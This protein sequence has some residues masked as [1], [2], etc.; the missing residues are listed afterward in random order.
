[1]AHRRFF[2]PR[3]GKDYQEG[4]MG[5]RTLVLGAY[6]YCWY[7][8]CRYFKECVVEGRVAD[9]DTVCPEYERMSDRD[10]YRLSN[11][12]IIEIDSY[13]EGEHYP[14]YDSFTHRML[15]KIHPP[16][17]REKVLPRAGV[18]CIL[19]GESGLLQ[20]DT[21]LPPR[22]GRGL[23]LRPV[24]TGIHA[25]P[26]GIR[27]RAAR[28]PASGG[29]GVDRAAA[30]VPRRHCASLEGISLVRTG[31]IEMEAL[32]AWEYRVGYA[33][34]PARPVRRNKAQFRTFRA[35]VRMSP[36]SLKL[37]TEDSV[38][39]LAMILKDAYGHGLIE[40]VERSDRSR[41]IVCVGE[42]EDIV[43]LIDNIRRKVAAGSG[44]R[45]LTI[46]DIQQFLG[47]DIRHVP[48]M[49]YRLN[50]L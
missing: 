43:R 9:Y 22:A 14:A 10:Y 47:T 12:N 32:E 3:V 38:S 35:I 41:A 11:S 29:A 16:D 44:K 23:F 31:V 40:V 37:C 45:G 4:F 19:L 42:D 48:Q 33:G 50:R 24:G 18:A 25:G 20:L 28:A 36:I 34:E 21:A 5:H 26:P 27:G 13:L 39:N 30:A 15:G 8:K 49:L 2:N 17:A 6:H 7:G 46:D 1:M